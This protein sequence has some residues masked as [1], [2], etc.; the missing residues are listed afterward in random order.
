[1]TTMHSIGITTDYKQ[2]AKI[3][4]DGLGGEGL[5]LGHGKALQVLTMFPGGIWPGH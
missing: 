4:R 5:T 2:Q 1:M 3:L